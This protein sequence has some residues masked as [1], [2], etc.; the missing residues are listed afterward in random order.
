M[1]GK[2]D[3]TLFYYHTR[4]SGY[5]TTTSS[6]L[7]QQQ[8]QPARSLPTSSPSNVSLSP[9]GQM[10]TVTYF[11]PSIRSHAE[12]SLSSSLSSSNTIP[13]TLTTFSQMPSTTLTGHEPS[14]VINARLAE[15][16]MIEV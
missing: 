1:I 2:L 8:Q 9:D 12:S 5:E 10:M 16:E 6:F 14:H 7:E 15:Q 11:C 4:D 13:R 3:R